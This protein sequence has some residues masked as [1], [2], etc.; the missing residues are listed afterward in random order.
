M[1]TM[2]NR[3]TVLPVPLLLIVVLLS[4]TTMPLC[5]AQVGGGGGGGGGPPAPP[6]DAAAAPR[7]QA[8]GRKK[9]KQSLVL[10]EAADTATQVRA[11]STKA[12]QAGDYY[13]WNNDLWDFDEKENVP[14]DMIGTSRGTCVLLASD[15]E[16]VPGHCMFTLTIH[17]P[18]S[19]ESSDKPI[20]DDK[21]MI[22]GDVDDLHWTTTQTMAVV[23]GTGEYEGAAGAIDISN[24]WGFFIYDIYLD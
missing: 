9:G 16:Q 11:D 17:H 15:V 8:K 12:Y 2:M 10:A 3:T 21:L 13:V 5:Q 19:D 22:M 7:R 4:A 1:A 18:N 24:E 23:G 20:Q 14:T 6:Q